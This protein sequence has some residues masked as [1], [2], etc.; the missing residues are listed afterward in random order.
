MSKSAIWIGMSVGSFIGGF[1]PTLW[2]D[3]FISFTSVTLT[4]VGGIIGIY[5]AYKLTEY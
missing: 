5:V 2:G 4:A 3:N 1:I